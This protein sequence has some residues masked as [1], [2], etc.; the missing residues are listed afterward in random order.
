M[1][2]GPYYCARYDKIVAD[3]DCMESYQNI[4]ITALIGYT[5]TFASSGLIDGTGN[6]TNDRVFILSGLNDTIV[7]QGASNTFTWPADT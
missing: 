7:H 4:D 2:L 3:T 1:V 6:M 5:S